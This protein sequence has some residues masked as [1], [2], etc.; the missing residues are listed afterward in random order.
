MR[1]AIDAGEPRSRERFPH[2]PPHTIRCD[3][4]AYMR[5]LARDRRRARRRPAP[6]AHPVAARI[7]AASRP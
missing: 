4:H 6:A 1:A 2:E 3:P 5:L 7:V